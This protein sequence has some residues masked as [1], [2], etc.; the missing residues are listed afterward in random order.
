MSDQQK[1]T[2]GCLCGGVRFVVTEPP[3]KVGTCHCRRCQR[4]SGSAF[5][6]G[7][8]FRKSAVQFTNGEPKVYR[9]SSI[10]ERGFCTGC[11]SPFIYWY[12]VEVMHSEDVWISLGTFDNP[13]QF[14]PTYHYAVE[15]EMTWL[16][17]DLPRLRLDEDAALASALESG[18][19]QSR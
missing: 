7:V 8:R 14:K 16:H 13:E 6:V 4:W 3:N 9:S 19:A 17:D 5:S 12:L 18:H 10:M 11:G 2:G 15:T 1:M